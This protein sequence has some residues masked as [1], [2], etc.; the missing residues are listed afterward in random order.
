[1]IYEK[2]G[3][4]QFIASYSCSYNYSYSYSY[5]Y[6]AAASAVTVNTVAYTAAQ[7][8]RQPPAR[9]PLKFQKNK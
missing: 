7:H 8:D 1:M 2:R 6:I 5:S 3:D 9:E 4:K